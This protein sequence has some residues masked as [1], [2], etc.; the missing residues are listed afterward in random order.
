MHSESGRKSIP[1]SPDFSNNL[2]LKDCGLINCRSRLG[3]RNPIREE[4]QQILT[5]RFRGDST[6]DPEPPA[7][8]T[9]FSK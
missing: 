4:I 1:R 6:S 2:K 5:D 7:L 3:V 8:H 9:D